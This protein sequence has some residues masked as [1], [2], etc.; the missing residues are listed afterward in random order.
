MI[1]VDEPESE[2]ITEGK[3][4]RTPLMLRDE[5][6]ILRTEAH[7]IDENSSDDEDVGD[8]GITVPQ[9]ESE[10][11]SQTSMLEMQPESVDG[12]IAI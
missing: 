2:L 12:K 3:D 1:A 11:Q 5:E 10:Q 4:D 6:T 7:K 8:I 9:P